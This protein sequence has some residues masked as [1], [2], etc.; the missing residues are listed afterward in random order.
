MVQN[1]CSRL[2][3]NQFN[4]S[5]NT[6][7]FGE[8]FQ[9]AIKV[10]LGKRSGDYYQKNYRPMQKLKLLEEH[11]GDKIDK[12]MNQVVMDENKDSILTPIYLF[13]RNY[14]RY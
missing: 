10:T 2:E 7:I 14:E 4:K 5:T 9:D 6:T 12:H 13:L 3:I 8:V 11:Y 1:S